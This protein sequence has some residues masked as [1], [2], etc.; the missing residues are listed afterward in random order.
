MFLPNLN[1]KLPNF[2]VIFVSTNILLY[3]SMSSFNGFFAFRLFS[4]N[5]QNSAKKTFVEDDQ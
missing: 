2:W 3:F 1:L 5:Q 4:V